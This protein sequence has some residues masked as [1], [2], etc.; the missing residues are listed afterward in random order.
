[1]SEKKISK[2]LLIKSGFW[3]TVSN[4]MTRAMVFITMPIFTMLM[5]KTE[6]GN[7]SVFASWQAI[8]LAFCGIEVYGTLNRARFDF[9]EKNEF[10]GYI[11]SS[12]VL[13]S[14][15]TG[16]IFILYI[17]CP[18]IFDRFFLIERKYMFILFAYLF[19]YPSLAMFQAKQRVE[20]K[21]KLSATLSSILTIASSLL[22]VLLVTKLQ[23][24][25]LLGRIVGQY[26]LLI[27]AGFCFYIYFICC[28]RKITVKSWKYALRIGL[29]L[30]FSYVGSQILLSS[31]NLVLKHMCSAEEVSYLSV[32]QTTSH[33]M[34]I[35]V[36]TINTAWAPWFFDMLRVNETQEIKKTYR[37]YLWGAI[38]C[39]FGVL[40][41][42]PEIISILGGAKY[43]ES[44][45][46]LP[47]YILCGVFTVLTAQFVNL[48]T[49]HKKSEY[50]AILTGIVAVLNVILNVLGVKLWGYRA[51]CYTTVFCQIILISLHY[52]IT[53]RMGIKELLP[54]K[55]LLIA[56][57]ASVALIPI[58]LLLYQS[59]LIRYI[60]IGACFIAMA[61]IL[62]VKKKE[63][64][65]L[66]NA[67]KTKR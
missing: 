2:G 7:F 64:L 42:G 13:S 8:L 32:T 10:D 4:F 51:V 54:V 25:R 60:C 12:L 19:T 48:E 47:P 18:G 24:D 5:S 43:N 1:M 15:F 11:S 40:L 30:V 20:Y 52:R 39:T 46:I 37:I 55:H 26:G 33:I 22:A 34:L 28:S 67:M 59:M 56:L 61:V 27:I 62:C 21:Y 49:Y 6:Y 14:I 9:P 3:Y 16:L 23:D 50:A 66:M 38:V 44:I 17:A 29:P 31:D 53:V 58:A 41:I 65:H 36:Q 35:L 57:V 45:Y 63:I